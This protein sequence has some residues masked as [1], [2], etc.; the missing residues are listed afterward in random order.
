MVQVPQSNQVQL[1]T[2]QA[3]PWT[4]VHTKYPPHDKKMFVRVFTHSWPNYYSAAVS[5]PWFVCISQDQES[6]INKSRPGVLSV[7][8][9]ST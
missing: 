7:Q 1:S 4:P 2:R 8:K 6:A 9:E 3:A 5:H